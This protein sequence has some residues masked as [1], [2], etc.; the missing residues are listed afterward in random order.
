MF[1]LAMPWWEFLV[2]AVIVYTVLLVLVRISGKRTVGQFTPFDLL[3]VMLLS[4]GVTNS[5]TGEDSS[6]VG[7]LMTAATLVILNLS[8]A[9]LSARSQIVEKAVEGSPVLIGRNG[10]VFEDVLKRHRLTQTE[11]DEALHKADCK[12][13]D[14]QCAFLETDGEITVTTKNK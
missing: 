7:G 4:E 5:L 1:D 13:T 2:R 10:K 9:F 12:L 6:L 8:M 11:V 3:V 14:M